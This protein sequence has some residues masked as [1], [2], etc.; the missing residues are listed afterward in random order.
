M[1]CNAKSESL[2][3]KPAVAVVGTGPVGMSVALTL[4]RAGV[5]TAVIESGEEHEDAWAASLSSAAAITPENHAPLEHTT[6]RRL[7]GTS[8][9]WGGRCV[10][11]YPIDFTPRPGKD[12]PGWPITYE[13]A[14]AEAGAAGGGAMF[15]A[16]AN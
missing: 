14:I 4:A 16:A 13:D 10:D 8:W 2:D 5:D 9:I 6:N 15:H 11:F 3:I 1:I 12:V 7:G